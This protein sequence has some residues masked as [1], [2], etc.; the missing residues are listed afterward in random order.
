MIF[1][2]E[3]SAIWLARSRAVDGPWHKAVQLAT[4]EGHKADAVVQFDVFDQ[5]QGKIIYFQT[6]LS[7]GELK[8][9][10]YDGNA[11][12]YRVDLSDP[13]LK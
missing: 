8:T 6:T 1:S 5:E 12:M 3:D 7:A 13:R 10:R 4:H 11:M 2:T 9:P